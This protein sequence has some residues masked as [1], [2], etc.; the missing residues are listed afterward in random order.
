[1]NKHVT[2]VHEEKKPF[3]WNI[4]DAGFEVMGTWTDSLHQFMKEGECSVTFVLVVLQKKNNLKNHVEVVH[5]GKKPFPCILCDT[6]AW[7][8]DSLKFLVNP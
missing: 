5:K 6:R 3:K 2:T 8:E 4:C 1:M 7:T